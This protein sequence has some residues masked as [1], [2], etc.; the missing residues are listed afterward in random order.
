MRRGLLDRCTAEIERIGPVAG[1]VG[2]AARSH[3]KKLVDGDRVSGIDLFG[4][5]SGKVGYVHFPAVN[6]SSDQRRRNA[7]CDRP[8]ALRHGNVESGRVVF[9]DQFSVLHDRHGGRSRI[10]AVNRGFGSDGYS[11]ARI[12]AAPVHVR[13]HIVRGGFFERYAGQ[14]G[15]DWTERATA[16]IMVGRH[17]G[18]HVLSPVDR[19]IKQFSRHEF[20][21]FAETLN[22]ERQIAD[23]S[24]ERSLN[25]C[26]LPFHHAF[27]RARRAVALG[28][29]DGTA[30]EQGLVPC[31]KRAIIAFV[32][33]LLRGRLRGNRGAEG[34][35]GEERSG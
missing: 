2:V 14:V 35:R 3:A 11:A 6:C 34:E 20:G 4:S 13:C 12:V 23:Q 32:R 7:L 15:A 30:Q 1:R 25:A 8:G 24:V 5:Q 10:L 9:A 33:R 28:I 22:A 16:G 19:D 18:G 26:Q 17:S 29:G 21:F 31:G 27:R